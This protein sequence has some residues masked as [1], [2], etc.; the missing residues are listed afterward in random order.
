[1]S[2]THETVRTEKREKKTQTQKAKEKTTEK[3]QKKKAD[4]TVNETEWNQLELHRAVSCFGVG[5]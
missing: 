3:A 4:L 1:M 5:R 2:H